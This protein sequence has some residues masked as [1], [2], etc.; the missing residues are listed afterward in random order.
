VT[1]RYALVTGAS[2]GIG[3]AIARRL[4]G[5]GYD[6]TLA[7][8]HEAPLDEVAGELVAGG[9]D[10]QTVTGDLSNE[11]DVRCVADTHLE[12]FPLLHLLVLSA[13]MSFAGE[14]ADFPLRRLDRM[15]A[16]N[17][18][19]PLVLVQRCLPALRMAAA[20]DPARG[21]RVVAL[22]SLSGVVAEPLLGVYGSTKAALISLCEAITVEESARGV[23]ATAVS[24]GFVD[25]DMGA[26]ATDH[27]ERSA[28]LEA[29]DVAELVVSLTRLSARA[30]VPNLVVARAGDQV[31]RA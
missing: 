31:W 29:A 24:P 18:R 10:V 5:E 23:S 3:A 8:R 21:A 25:T 13:G 26:W 22:A 27:I 7:A 1:R 19:A 15:V 28:M 4:A 9:A 6:L 14:V 12:R 30:V 2:R 16:V 20:E 17:L 11:E